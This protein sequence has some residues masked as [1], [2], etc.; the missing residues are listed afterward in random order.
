M[1]SCLPLCVPYVL[2]KERIIVNLAE[3][4]VQYVCATFQ[5]WHTS[6]GCKCN[7]QCAL[8]NLHQKGARVA[9]CLEV[10]AQRRAL[11]RGWLLNNAQ[12][13]M[14]NYTAKHG[15]MHNAQLHMAHILSAICAAAWPSHNV[16]LRFL[17]G[18][19]ACTMY[20][21]YC[22]QYSLTLFGVLQPQC[23]VN[24]HFPLCAA[25]NVH[26]LQYFLAA[27]DIFVTFWSSRNFCVQH[28]SCCLFSDCL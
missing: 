8:C 7:V 4:I 11:Q 13:T 10:A 14:N 17:A 19:L 18:H 9:G 23:S 3:S 25:F 27:S 1:Y 26:C 15:T 12:C 2:R 16:Q 20:S 28:S 21:L 6:S 24:I 5:L 22:L